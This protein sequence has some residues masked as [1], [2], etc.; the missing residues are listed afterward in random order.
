MSGAED[1]RAKLEQL[2]EQLLA[3][4]ARTAREAA[5]DAL[6]SALG[7]AATERLRGRVL[8]ARPGSTAAPEPTLKAR[9]SRAK[10][11]PTEL[12]VAMERLHRF[13]FEHP[14]VRTEEIK[15]ALGT[16]RRGMAHPLR[17]L[18]AEGILRTEGVK[19]STRYYPTGASNVRR[20]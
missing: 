10:R 12:A 8:G 6:T 5:L 2:I 14:G 7:P 13:V 9:A 11:T 16:S 4:V 20:A 19:R 1:H 18:V 3:E 15:Q 17:R